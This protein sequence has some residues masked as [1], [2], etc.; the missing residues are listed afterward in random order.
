MKRNGIGILSLVVISLMRPKLSLLPK[1]M[2][3]SPSR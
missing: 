2:C 1:L 3:R